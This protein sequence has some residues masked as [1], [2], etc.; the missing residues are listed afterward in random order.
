M[1]SSFL[2]W[3]QHCFSIKIIFPQIWMHLPLQN[4]ILSVSWVTHYPQNVVTYNKN[5]KQFRLRLPEWFFWSHWTRS[6]IGVQLQ[7]SYTALLLG[8]D[9]IAAG[10]MEDLAM[11]LIIPQAPWAYSHGGSKRANEV[12]EASWGQ[13]SETANYFCFMLLFKASHKL[14]EEFI[15]RPNCEWAHQWDRQAEA[16]HPVHFPRNVIKYQMIWEGSHIIVR[17]K[18]LHM[19]L[20]F[21][22]WIFWYNYFLKLLLL[23]FLLLQS[24]G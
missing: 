8:V 18:R 20:F 16:H 14:L 12:C 1:I 19:V 2:S 24:E 9:W 7:I 6:H 13:G 17:S 3:K 21:S 11:C 10:V 4:S 22:I 5:L 23:E 15:R